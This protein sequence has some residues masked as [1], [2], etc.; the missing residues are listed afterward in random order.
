M[1]T[2]HVTIFSQYFIMTV[3]NNGA[4]IITVCKKK[5]RYRFYISFHIA[6]KRHRSKDLHIYLP[7]S[8]WKYTIIENSWGSVYFGLV[9]RPEFTYAYFICYTQVTR[10]Q[11]TQNV[12]IMMQ[13]RW[14]FRFDVIPFMAIR[15]HCCHVMRTDLQRLLCVT[16][17]QS[18]CIF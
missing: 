17:C 5:T 7:R 13:I 3:F 11:F 15:Y 12:G 1:G 2:D 10:V 6:R 4:M 8:V 18:K 14:K 9:S 16:V